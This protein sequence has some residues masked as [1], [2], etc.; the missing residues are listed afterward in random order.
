M[1]VS[2][3]TFMGESDIRTLLLPLSTDLNGFDIV[4]VMSPPY[5]A[6][7][8]HR[9]LVVTV[10]EPVV[11]ELPFY[12][13]KAKLTAYP[14]LLAESIVF[15]KRAHFIA[16]SETTRNKITAHFALPE[17]QISVIPCGVDCDGFA[18]SKKENEQPQI[19]LCSRLD[20][21]KNIPEALRAFSAISGLRSSMI[22]VGDGPERRK[23][24][25]LATKAHKEITFT[26]NVEP[27]ELRAILSRSEIFVTASLSEGFGLSLLEAMSAGCAVIVSNIGLVYNT[28][29][30]LTKMMELLLTNRELVRKLGK[31][32]R[33]TALQYSWRNVARRILDLYE[34]LTGS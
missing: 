13:R 10:A 18:P 14:A 28:Q 22:I 7:E 2:V 30:E 24:V 16:I 9:H 19:V 3:Q 32:A 11:T 1:G 4:H 34:T 27:V 12:A 17:S 20:R 21:R 15:R 5:A 23:L 6:L 31:K 29:E 33:E 25:E 26:G 8:S